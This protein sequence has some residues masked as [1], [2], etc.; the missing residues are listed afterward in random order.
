MKKSIVGLVLLLA[1]GSLAFAGLGGLGWLGSL[2]ILGEERH[3]RSRV[4]AYWQARV[5]NDAGTIADCEHPRQMG[6]LQEG[7]LDT[8]KYEIVD[9]VIDGEEAVATVNFRSRLRHPMLSQKVRDVEVQDRWEHYQGRWYREQH[10]VGFLDTVKDLQGLWE[11]P[12]ET[13]T[14]AQTPTGGE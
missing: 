11:P 9:L 14:V 13:P 7:L 6:I 1:A 8:E 4:E 10:P 3:L 5:D 12:T 2:G